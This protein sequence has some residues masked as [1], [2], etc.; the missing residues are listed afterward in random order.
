MACSVALLKLA[1]SL[2]RQ[3][4][5]VLYDGKAFVGETHYN[6]CV[7]VLSPPI[8]DILAQLDI[9]FPHHLIQRKIYTYVLH[10]EHRQIRLSDPSSPSYS[11]L[12]VQ[13][14]KY[15]L[16]QAYAH[17][18]E[19]RQGRV[20]DLEFLPDRV[21]VYAES[22]NCEAAVVFGAFG[23]DPG[24]AA[25]LAQATSYHPPHFLTSLVTKIHPPSQIIDKFGDDIHAFLPPNPHIEF[26]AITPKQNHLTI[27]FAGTA[28]DSRDMDTFLN[29]LP[30]RQLL[31]F[32]DPAHPQN[33]KDFVYF[34]G[35][36]PISIARN[37][38]G[39]RYVCLGDAA[40]LV[41][42]FK[43]KGINSACQTA[44]WAAET[45]LTVGVSQH[46]FDTHYRAACRSILNDAPYGKAVRQLASIGS[47]LRLM[48]HL[49]AVAQQEPTLRHALF[50]AVSAHRTYRAIAADLFYPPTLLRLLFAFFKPGL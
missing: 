9:P 11:L 14:D 26:G 39:N 10:G 21:N 33:P 41:R 36:F 16:D 37:F 20:T 46:A 5:V 32:A 31:S 50:D 40:G 25:L 1:R 23:L 13:F 4:R 17:G 45:A 28:I 49:I 3:I 8:E 34:R 42:A 6:Q 15:M 2:G 12:R 30:V 48:D 43:G 24:T 27:N 19:V 29:Y 47:R 38:Y 22:T 18:V 7:G 44:L 35:R